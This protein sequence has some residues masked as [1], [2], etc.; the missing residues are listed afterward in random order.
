MPIE[1]DFEPQVAAQMRAELVRFSDRCHY[2]ETRKRI[3]YN[4]DHCALETYLSLQREQM[5]LH[6]WLES[7]KSHHDLGQKAML[8]W[9]CKY[10]DK[11]ARYWRRTHAFIPAKQSPASQAS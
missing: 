3:V 11:F 1:E 9:V 2:D 5:E 10:S 6:K 7:E 8:E 4:D